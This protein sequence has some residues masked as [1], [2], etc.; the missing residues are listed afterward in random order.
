[1]KAWKLRSIWGEASGRAVASGEARG[2]SES[3]S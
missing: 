1:L 3:G 2:K